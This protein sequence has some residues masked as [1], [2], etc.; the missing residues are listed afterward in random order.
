VVEV[1]LGEEG[2]IGFEAYLCAGLI[3]RTDGL[4]IGAFDT[5]LEFHLMDGPVAGDRDFHPFADEVDDRCAY[6]MKPAGGF[7]GGSVVVLEFSTGAQGGED[8]FDSWDAFGGVNA[9]GDAAA[10]VDDRAGAIGINFDENAFRIAGQGLVDGVIDDFVDEVMKP[11]W[12]VSADVHTGAGA[13]VFHIVEDADHAFVVF[14]RNGRAG[15]GNDGQGCN[16][17]R[18]GRRRGTCGDTARLTLLLTHEFSLNDRI[19]ASVTR[20]ANAMIWDLFRPA[21]CISGRLFIIAKTA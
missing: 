17:R 6:A 20:F 12:V 19:S 10:I 21:G 7:V 18:G 16:G 15:H 5:T 9:D 2:V 14:G 1:D 13:D 11:A 4:E 3:C 8:D